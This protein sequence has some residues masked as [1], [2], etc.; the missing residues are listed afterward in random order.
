MVAEGFSPSGTWPPAMPSSAA[1]GPHGVGVIQTWI[2]GDIVPSTSGA[3]HEVPIGLVPRD[4]RRVGI[5]REAQVAVDVPLHQRA[6]EV[7]HVVE[8]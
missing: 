3:G 6:A 4:L 5:V 1:N 2:I 7:G 8:R